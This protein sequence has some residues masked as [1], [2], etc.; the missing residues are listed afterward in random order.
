LI[1]GEQFY[2]AILQAIA[3]AQH[4][5]LIEMYLVESGSV[6][7]QFVGL[8]TRQAHQGVIIK[9]LFDSFGANE[10]LQKDRQRL[11]DAG[12]ELVFYNP[13]RLVRFK[14]NLRRTHRKIIVIDGEIAFTGGAG[15]SEE[16]TVE[17]RG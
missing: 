3:Q 11:K 10:L 12:I 16:F 5:I 6:M 9:L 2:P 1:D 14:R 8:L 7:N 17:F 13:V 4:Y 15:L